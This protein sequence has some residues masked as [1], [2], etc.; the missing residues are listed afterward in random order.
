MNAIDL[1]ADLGLIALFLITANILVG[2]LIAVRYSPMRHWPRHRLDIFRL[3]RCTA[4]LAVAVTILHPVVLLFSERVR[5]RVRDIIA[6]LWSPQ[7]PVENTI[8]AV[9]LYLLLLILATS[10]W[11]L[12][13]NRVVWKRFHYLVYVAAAAL[14]VHGLLT[15]P[16]FDNTAVDWMDGEKVMVETCLLLV[17]IASGL[18]LRYRRKRD[19]SDRALGRGKYRRPERGRRLLQP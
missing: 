15:D 3:H 10:V 18:A 7:Q 14:F 2:L 19:G 11:R 13:M 16:T 17:A 4:Y 12:S 5:F 9:A 8:G 1:S 6:P